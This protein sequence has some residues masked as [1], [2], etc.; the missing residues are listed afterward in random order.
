MGAEVCRAIAADPDCEVV[1][2]VDPQ[3]AG[4]PLAQVASVDT[5]LTVLAEAS[6]D[7]R[8]DVAVDFTIGDVAVGNIQWCIENGVGA[9][10]GTTA[11]PVE[12]LER[13]RSLCEQKSGTVLIA[14]NFAIGA[15]LMMR[16]AE[17]AAEWMPDAE[18]IELHHPGKA[19][20][21]SGT[22]LSTASR[23]AAAREAAAADQKGNELVAGAR[24]ADK[25]GVR[26]HSVRLPGLVAHQEVIFGGLGQT[27]SI[28][29]DTTDRTSF[30]PGVLLAVKRIGE[31]KGFTVGLEK[32]L[33]I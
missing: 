1:A 33:G 3:Y 16:F 15:V 30:M 19:D 5:D 8:P 32:V 13:L 2:A 18:V 4:Q 14:P 9:V 21:P 23:I 31:V 10:V 20:A 11:I 6:A 12:E 17:L 28:R 27:L 22:A 24:G 7:S 26:V 25:E 29:H